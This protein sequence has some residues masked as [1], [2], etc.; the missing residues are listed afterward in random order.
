LIKKE[1]NI[2][3]PCSHPSLIFFLGE[4]EQGGN[5]GGRLKKSSMEQSENVA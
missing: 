4:S 5:R 3:L 2:L 1:K